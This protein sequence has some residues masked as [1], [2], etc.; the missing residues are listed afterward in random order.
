MKVRVTPTSN[1]LPP[2]RSR[3][4][5]LALRFSIPALLAVCVLLAGTTQ[6]PVAQ[7]VAS[8]DKHDLAP[9]DRHRKV[10]KLVSNVIGRS[11]YRQSPIN[12]QVSDL[13]LDRYQEALDGSKSYFLASDIQ[14]FEKLRYQLDDAVITGQLEPVFAIFNRFQQR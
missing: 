8:V 3:R 4:Q 7:A 9:T 2:S 12:D 6:T 10:S 14:E 1:R 13:V 5:R 11:H